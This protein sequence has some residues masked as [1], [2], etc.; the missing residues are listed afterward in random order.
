[1]GIL[2]LGAAL[3][4]C[5]CQNTQHNKLGCYMFSPPVLDT[6]PGALVTHYV[7]SGGHQ[8]FLIDTHAVQ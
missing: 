8:L 5:E 1:M 4:S 6:H 7:S 2:G 3:Q